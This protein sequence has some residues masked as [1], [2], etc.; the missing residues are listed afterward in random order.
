M[1]DS[2]GTE[3]RP[4]LVRGE[5]STQAAPN[6]PARFRTFRAFDAFR[7]FRP[8]RRRFLASATAAAPVSPRPPPVSAA[9]PCP[10][11]RRTGPTADPAPG[12]PIMSSR[13]A[14]LMQIMAHPDDDLYF[15]NPDCQ[16]MVDSG[17][18]LVCVYVTAGEHNGLN[19]V[20][21]RARPRPRT[22]RSYSSARHQGLRQAYAAMLGLDMFTPWQKG[23]MTL[24]R[25][26]GRPR[27]T[28]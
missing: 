1:Y 26:T 2:R 12:M 24:R 8:G 14:Q 27:S 3:L 11:A 18:P 16:Q 17:V 4:A 9:A 5:R 23:V 6:R 25:A 7:A 21:G 15:M 22:G 13:R 20:P 10:P 28:R 19:R